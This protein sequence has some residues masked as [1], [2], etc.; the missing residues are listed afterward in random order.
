MPVKPSTTAAQHSLEPTLPPN[1]ERASQAD[2]VEH[3]REHE[4]RAHPQDRR[5]ARQHVLQEEFLVG[6]IQR[7]AVQRDRP[8]RQHGDQRHQPAHRLP[9]PA[10]QREGRRGQHQDRLFVDSPCSRRSGSARTARRPAA[11]APN[12]QSMARQALEEAGRPGVRRARWLRACGLRALR[13]KCPS[14]CL[15][16]LACVSLRRLRQPGLQVV[17]FALEVE[18]LALGAH[19]HQ[20]MRAAVLRRA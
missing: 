19:R 13:A 1:G 9:V 4:Q 7:A 15:L 3:G 20:R 16:M 11:P 10:Q 6:R 5:L 17:E 12:S 18:R 2:P 14:S 8:Q